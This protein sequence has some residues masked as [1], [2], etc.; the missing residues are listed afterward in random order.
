MYFFGDK[1][2]PEQYWIRLPF[3]KA[4][5]EFMDLIC[6]N[7]K[8]T[9]VSTPRGFAKT[10]IVAVLYTVYK[11]VYNLERF[12]VIIG[13]NDDAGKENLGNIRDC[14][15][16]NEKIQAVYGKLIPETRGVS[17]VRT[18][19]ED[20]QHQITLTNGIRLRSI[21]MR[22]SI[23]GKVKV[24]RPTLVIVEDPQDIKSMQEVPTLEGHQRFFDH[25]VMYCLDPLYGKVVLIG[26]NLGIGC[27]VNSLMKDNRFVQLV[28]D[29][30]IGSDGESLW[31][32]M[33]PTAK[34]RAEETKMRAMGKGHVYDQER[35]NIP[36]DSLQKRIEGYQFHNDTIQ[37]REGRNYLISDIYPHPIEVRLV[38]AVD[39]AFSEAKSSDKRAQVMMAFGRF[40]VEGIYRSG[41]WVLD[42][43]Y[44]HSDPSKIPDSVMSRHK[45]WL[46]DDFVI[47]A[48]GGQLI[49]KYLIENK[50][51]EDEFYRKHPFSPHY[52]RYVHQAKGD[53]IWNT[54]GLLCRNEQF[55]LKQTHIDLMRELDNFGYLVRNSGIHILDAITMANKF[56]TPPAPSNTVNLANIIPRRLTLE[57]SP[58]KNW[59]LW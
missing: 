10:T 47:E 9:L 28:Y 20:S 43:Q 14:L 54:I 48:N 37:Y 11:I 31:P 53:R 44:D 12:I 38:Y 33:Y 35:R 40:P 41:I 36:D 21:G 58:V 42:Y 57:P 29:D 19:S 2:I 45:Q 6:A 59:R 23:R 39:P 16:V 5:R 46:F 52:D 51:T 27:T 3:S 7:Y 56:I 34:L 55:F 24:Y 25:D 18:K 50:L 1:S 22:G 32:E 17:A 15:A 49:F 13:K 4:H 8:Y 30:I 26:N